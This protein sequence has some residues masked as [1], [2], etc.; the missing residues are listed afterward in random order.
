MY[1][2]V[3]SLRPAVVTVIKC[4]F[5][6]VKKLSIDKT[7]HIWVM[8]W[9]SVKGNGLDNDW[10]TTTM[11]SVWLYVCVYASV[12]SFTKDGH[13]PAREINIIGI[14]KETVDSLVTI[15][16]RTAN[17]YCWWGPVVFSAGVLLCLYIYVF[18][19]IPFSPLGGWGPD[20]KME[21]KR[22]KSI[23][24][25]SNQRVT[26]CIY[27]YC[28]YVMINA[29]CVTLPFICTMVQHSVFQCC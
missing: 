28:I 6:Q 16:E 27:L 21:G 2:P 15:W 8:Q 29:F 13:V 17:K 11:F 1:C 19:I 7:S 26:V 3:L 24:L 25:L 12:T 14:K 9:M 22:V 4:Q 10:I 23:L 5:F 20:D 18:S